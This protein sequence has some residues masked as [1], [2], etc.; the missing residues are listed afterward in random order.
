MDDQWK[1]RPAFF[2]NQM[3]II[4]IA[5]VVMDSGKKYV[6][7]S[8]TLVNKHSQSNSRK[9]VLLNEMSESS[10]LTTV[11]TPADKKVKQPFTDSDSHFQLT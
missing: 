11:L 5:L 3:D 2:S 9:A 4:I 6:G 10:R 7:I 1:D 8:E